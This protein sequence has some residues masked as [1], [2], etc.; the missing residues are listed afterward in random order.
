[1]TIQLNDQSI[2]VPKYIFEGVDFMVKDF[3][4]PMEFIILYMEEV[5]VQHH[6]L[7]I[8]DRPLLA[9]A[10]TCIKVVIDISFGNK[11]VFLN[12]FNIAVE[13]TGDNCILFVEVDNDMDEVMCETIASIFALGSPLRCDDDMTNIYKVAMYDSSVG[14]DFCLDLESRDAKCGTH[15]LLTFTL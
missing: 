13:P 7:I 11:K 10:N 8:L 9:M 14:F 12:I 4:F 15:V 6:M 5:D 2:K 1:M 3:I